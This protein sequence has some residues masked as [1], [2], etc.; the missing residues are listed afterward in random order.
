MTEKEILLCMAAALARVERNVTRAKA[1][2]LALAREH[3]ATLGEV[4]EAMM[5][6]EV[7]DDDVIRT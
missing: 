2:A 6:V 7:E 3:G 4:A 5:A 1:N